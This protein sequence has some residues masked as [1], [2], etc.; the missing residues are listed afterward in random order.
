MKTLLASLSTLALV[1]AAPA[2]AETKSTTQQ[3]QTQAQKS[4]GTSQL[5]ASNIMGASIMNG[6]DESIGDVND[7]IV[8]QDGKIDRIIVGVGGFLGMGERNVAL[9]MDQ[10]NFN[11]NTDGNLKVMTQLTKNELKNMP[12]YEGQTATQ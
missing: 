10:L 3:Q 5:R 2:F 11:T 9:S 4:T 1:A 6:Q 7:I 8:T 12:A